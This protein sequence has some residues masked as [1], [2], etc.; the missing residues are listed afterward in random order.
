MSIVHGMSTE[1]IGGTSRTSVDATRL[2]GNGVNEMKPTQRQLV[3]MAATPAA[4]RD[5]ISID[6][7]GGNVVRLRDVLDPWQRDDFA[8]L[9]PAFA[10]AVHGKAVACER[11]RVWLERPR[12]HSKTSDIAVMACW[13]IFAAKRRLSAIAAAGDKDQARLL[14]DAIAR[15]VA[16]NPWLE[17]FLDVQ[18]HRVVNT[19]TDAT[20][21][22]ISS[23]AG[24]SY[25]LSPDLVI[26]DEVTHWSSREL[27]DSLLSASAKRSACAVVCISNAGFLD[28][29]QW[30]LREAVRLDPSWHFSRLDGPV[31]SWIDAAKLDEQRRLLPPLVFS[32]LWLNEW[33]SG[34]GDAITPA[35]LE[36]SIRAEPLDR[37]LPGWC[38]VAG[39]D[40]GIS[41][42][43]SAVV[44]LG[45][46][47]AIRRVVHAR[48]WLPSR[49]QRVD[50]ADVR[51]HLKDLHS[52][53]RLSRVAYD[54]FQAE[55]LAADLSKAGLPM[56]RVPFSGQNLSLMASVVLDSFSSGT[57]ELPNDPIL[58]SDLNRL[59]I[60]ERSYGMRLVSPRGQDGHG[61]L[62]S[63][64]AV[65]LLAAKEARGHAILPRSAMPCL[66]SPGIFG[67]SREAKAHSLWLECRQ[68]VARV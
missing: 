57:I 20:L 14:R 19:V 24:T 1:S 11:Q 34:S 25:G 63:S 40:L 18:A 64:L 47:D 5:F 65:A 42:D 66:G 8:L 48:R 12:G 60:E 9:D 7:A 28:S 38:Y 26:V 13:S 27:F 4:F 36:R 33:T 16:V 62:A 15:L 45:K 35:D 59:R 3:E 44:V 56:Y 17:K 61:D 41:K 54:P 29:W 30:K 31:A 49:G 32:R 2:A 67:A 37:G 55:L 52:R 6:G 43:A 50:L 58:I 10:R 51:A 21:E 22:I 23:D 68:A 46:R 39:V 53:F